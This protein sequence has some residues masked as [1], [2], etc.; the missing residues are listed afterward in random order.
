M[1]TYLTPD[2][3]LN[4]QE[5]TGEL[6][7]MWRAVIKAKKQFKSTDALPG[8]VRQTYLEAH[9]VSMEKLFDS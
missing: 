3:K 2:N 1:A 5:M 7:A 6:L 9:G 8:F 4:M